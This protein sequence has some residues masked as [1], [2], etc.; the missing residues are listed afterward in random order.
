MVRGA[1]TVGS[2]SGD[3][4]R[5]RR[6]AEAVWLAIARQRHGRGSPAMVGPSPTVG[7]LRML[8]ARTGRRRWSRAWLKA[9]ACPVSLVLDP[10]SCFAI[11]QHLSPT[12]VFPLSSFLCC[13]VSSFQLLFQPSASRT[14]VC[15]LALP[16]WPS[17]HL[18]PSL[19]GPGC[20]TPDE[21]RL[22]SLDPPLTTR[23]NRL[24]HRSSSPAHSF[25]NCSELCS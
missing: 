14:T 2:A 19:L 17:V 16:V 12:P 5:R 18:L 6:T 3:R 9:P 4:G 20:H 24:V 13:S 10:P 21:Q 1:E 25:D 11:Q 15:P 22:L 23:N 8:G 7:S